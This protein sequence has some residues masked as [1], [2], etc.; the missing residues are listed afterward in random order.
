[1][2]RLWDLSRTPAPSLASFGIPGYRLVRRWNSSGEEQV[3]LSAL[4]F[5][6]QKAPAEAGARHNSI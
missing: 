5:G 6:H 2:S 4:G 1:L 3:T